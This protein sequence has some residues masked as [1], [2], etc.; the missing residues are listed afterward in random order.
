[1]TITKNS[2][3]ILEHPFFKAAMKKYCSGDAA[4]IRH[5]LNELATHVYLKTAENC[6]RAYR[7]NV[8]NFNMSVVMTAIKEVHPPENLDTRLPIPKIPPCKV[9]MLLPKNKR[10]YDPHQLKIEFI[11]TKKPPVRVALVG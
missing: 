3:A 2:D 7:L 5:I 6:S 4:D 9:V 8:K 11:P 1:M 10:H